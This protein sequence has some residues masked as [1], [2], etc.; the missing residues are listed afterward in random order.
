MPAVLPTHPIKETQVAS[1]PATGFLNTQ[2]KIYKNPAS[3][4]TNVMI[5]KIRELFIVYL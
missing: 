4:Y 3:P 1:C 5:D 2:P